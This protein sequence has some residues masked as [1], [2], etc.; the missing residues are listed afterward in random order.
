MSRTTELADLY[1]AIEESARLLDISC[2]RGKVWP[3]L[4]AYGGAEDALV[5]SVIAF[6]LATDARHAGELDCRFTIPKDVDPYALAL[7]QGFIMETD[8][9]VGTFLSDLRGRCPVECYAIDFGV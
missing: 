4:A 5:E 3:I 2:S 1:S 9:P 6:R 7:S 8:R